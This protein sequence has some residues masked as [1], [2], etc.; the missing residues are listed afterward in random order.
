MEEC[1][2]CRVPLCF[3]V[4]DVNLFFFLAFGGREF[5]GFEPFSRVARSE[6]SAAGWIGT[7]FAKTP[8]DRGCLQDLY[9]AIESV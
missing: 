4:Y 7:L 8:S 2:W 1:K 6:I 5:L 9:F 3:P